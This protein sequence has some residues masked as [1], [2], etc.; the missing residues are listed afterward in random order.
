MYIN[1][2]SKASIDWSATEPRA[3]VGGGASVRWCV[4]CAPTAIRSG[5]KRIV[6]LDDNSSGSVSRGVRCIRANGGL[7]ALA[8]GRSRRSAAAACALAV[9]CEWR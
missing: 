7:R 3:E 6:R 9:V 5:S 1:I 2:H 8:G 4:K